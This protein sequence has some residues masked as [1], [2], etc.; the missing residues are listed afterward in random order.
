[1]IAGDLQVHLVSR[2]VSLRLA[3][4]GIRGGGEGGR[5]LS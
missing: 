2:V 3:L 1:M 4:V 5:L